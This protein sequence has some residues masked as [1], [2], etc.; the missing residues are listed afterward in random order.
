[1]N[2]L[3]GLMPAIEERLRE[4]LTVPGDAPAADGTKAIMNAAG[5]NE[6]NALLGEGYF[7]NI[8]NGYMFFLPRLGAVADDNGEPLIFTMD[9]ILAA[10][11]KKPRDVRTPDAPL[12]DDD[13]DAFQKRM[14]Q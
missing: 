12:T 7:R 10:G 3:T 6:V 13:F 4:A 11:V 1:M 8:A 14:Q 9:D 5:Q 2:G